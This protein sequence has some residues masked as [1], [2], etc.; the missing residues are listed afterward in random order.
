MTDL[1]L[2]LNIAVQSL[3][4]NV[5]LTSNLDDADAN[6]LLAWGI[7]ATQRA[8]AASLEFQSDTFF[9]DRFRAVLKTMRIINKWAGRRMEY[10]A[11]GNQAALEK[12]LARA[13]E[14][15][16]SAI[17]VPSEDQVTRFMGTAI[18]Q[19]TEGFITALLDLICPSSN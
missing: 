13:G 18:L 11:A 19:P 1:E 12:I 7:D 2:D 10:D 5:S 6:R 15:G 3:L 8:H 4:E 9:E 14:I 16:G 17:V